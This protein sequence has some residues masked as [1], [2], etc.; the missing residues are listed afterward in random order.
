M[1]GI[2]CGTCYF[3]VLICAWEWWPEKKGLV[4]GLILG[5]MGVGGFTFSLLSTKLVNPNNDNP[6]IYVPESDI[7]FFDSSVADRVPFMI[8][9]LVYI[10]IPIVFIAVMLVNRPPYDE[11][12]NRVQT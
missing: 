8:R 3:P 7:T 1:N 2:G 4:T 10:W 6:T 12:N 5:G 9:T 11:N